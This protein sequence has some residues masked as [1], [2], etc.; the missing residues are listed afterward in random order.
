MR[1]V[2]DLQSCQSGSRFGGIGRYSL[3]LAKAMV[4]QPRGHDFWVVLNS[5]LPEAIPIVRREFME[6][7]PPDRIK[8]IN[9]SG[10]V[11]EADTANRI[12]FK[13][14]SLT[15]EHYLNELR[16]DFTHVS[17][18]IEGLYEE[19]VTSLG[20]L[21]PAERTAVTLYDLI[22]LV[23]REKYLAEEFKF[24]WYKSKISYLEKAGLLLSISE[25]SRQEAIDLLGLPPDSI[26]NMSS[27]V[28][29]NFRPI[30]IPMDV[31]EKLRAKFGIVGDFLM[32]TGSFDQRKNH[33]LLIKAYA[34]L[35][36][37]LRKDYQLVIVGNGWD[38]AYQHLRSIAEREGMKPSELIFPGHI[39]DIELLQLYNLCKLFVFPSLREGFGLPILEA[40]SCGTPAIGSNTTSIPEVIGMKDAL[41]DPTDYQSIGK[42]IHE[43]LTDKNF[44]RKLVDHAIPHASKFS[45]DRSAAIALDAF[46]AHD[47]KIKRNLQGN[48]NCR[49]AAARRCELLAGK[50]SASYAPLVDQI[51]TIE[52]I[53]T[54][55][56]SELGSYAKCIAMNTASNEALDRTECSKR[57]PLHIGWVTTWNT[58]CGIATYTIPVIKAIP[59]CHWI[60]APYEENLVEPD[61]DNVIRSW[62]LGG[63][64]GL[65]GLSAALDRTNINA[66]VIQFN[67]GFYDFSAFSD[68]LRAQASAGRVVFVILHSTQDPDPKILDRKLSDLADSFSKC[69]LFVHAVHDVERLNQLGQK[70]N[71]FLLPLGMHEE[72]PSQIKLPALAGKQVVAT[73]GFALPNK[74]LVELV[75]AFELVSHEN[76]KLQLL[77]VN[78]EFPAPESRAY[79]AQIQDRVNKK[80]LNGKV[81]M[82]NDYLSNEDSIGYLRCA[83]LIV[84]P[85]QNTTESSSG[86]A[87]MAL[88]S[89]RTVAVTPL[90][91]FDDMR[92][93]VLTLPGTSPTDMANGMKDILKDIKMGAETI[94]RVNSN[95][96]LWV[97]AHGFS[98]V[99]RY[100]FSTLLELLESEVAK[101]INNQ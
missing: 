101:K 86:S 98:G 85:Y 14:A 89:G 56:E 32:F 30:D 92:N 1:I 80:G 35:P 54:V 13:T 22:P 10:P 52:G 16:P 48:D 67:Y 61:G 8:T 59:A 47:E 46:E 15:R 78:A 91:L 12:R 65:S 2:I 100:L 23:E 55:V 62:A 45:W 34:S 58:R 60:F 95:A 19:S 40:M 69:F 37:K 88:A 36:Q 81:T 24:N 42:K 9:F 93:A 44:Y 18:L 57:S 82:I 27:A 87:R 94:D 4:R 33:E 43:C 51:A 79:I 11:A 20:L 66:V 71:V 83:D 63:A 7:L 73:Y 97:K 76:P 70:D 77:M 25:F 21:T 31:A 39:S 64:G 28:D 50:P 74:G 90:A 3:A 49:K 17:S 75:D 96:H 68:F 29:S 5:L 26:V 84:I 53:H 72:E 41:F 99:G 38:G 6:L